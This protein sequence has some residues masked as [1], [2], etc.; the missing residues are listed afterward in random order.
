MQA[1]HRNKASVQ[2]ALQRKINWGQGDGG[3]GT[4]CSKNLTEKGTSFQ[5]QHQGSKEMSNSTASTGM[6]EEK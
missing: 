4:E 1:D 3:D 5:R 2:W 6:C